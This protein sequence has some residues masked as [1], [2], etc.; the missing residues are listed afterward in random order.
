MDVL[1]R[2]ALRI[3]SN[4][5]SALTGSG[6]SNLTGERIGCRLMFSG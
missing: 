2:V 1:G 3:S 5:C 4:I 6:R